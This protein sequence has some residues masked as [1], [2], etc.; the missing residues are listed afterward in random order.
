V[1]EERIANLGH[2]SVLAVALSS[3]SATWHGIRVQVNTTGATRTGSKNNQGVFIGQSFN[4]G[5]NTLLTSATLE[6]NRNGLGTANF[7]LKLHA[8]TGS[9]NLYLKS[10]NALVSATFSNSI[11]GDSLATSYEFTNLNWAMAPNTVSMIGIASEDTASVKWT[12]NQS[13][14]KI[15][16]TGFIT[17]YTGY[18]AQEGS[19]VDNGLHGATISAVPQPSTCITGLTGLLALGL[20][21]RN[22]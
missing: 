10:G 4:S 2:L 8:V 17:G 5:A 15:N 7:T 12:I 19:N 1:I 11:L 21:I 20:G 6:I 13:A 3:D 9:P 18:N 16:S 22:R 14:T